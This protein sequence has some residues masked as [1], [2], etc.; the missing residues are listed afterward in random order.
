MSSNGASLARLK[1][2]KLSAVR[3]AQIKTPPKR[4]DFFLNGSDLLVY[5]LASAGMETNA[6]A[7]HCSLTPSQVSYR[8]GIA[9]HQARARAHQEKR[10]F[11]SARKQY[12]R[13]TSQVS[14]L[15]I[16]QITDKH[17]HVKKFVTTVLDRR[18]LYNPQSK[19]VLKDEK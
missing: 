19:G 11:Y 12:R 13:G 9:E 14:K 7:H 2:R 3:A 6:I 18:G 5:M 4:V 15:I 17:S 1:L 8:L 10:P 16:S